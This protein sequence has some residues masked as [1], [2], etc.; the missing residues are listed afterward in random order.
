MV[1]PSERTVQWMKDNPE[2]HQ[3]NKDAKQVKRDNIRADAI[4]AISRSL[5]KTPE[6]AIRAF[7]N[8]CPVGVS[9]NGYYYAPVTCSKKSCPLYAFRNVNPNMKGNSAV[10]MDSIRAGK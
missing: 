6:K 7:C 1:T 5:H 4:R 9:R 3:A 8:A 10:V 2:K